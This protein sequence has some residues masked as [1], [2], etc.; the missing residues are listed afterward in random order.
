MK[1]LMTGT[2]L[3]AVLAIAAPAWAQTS[4]D[5]NRMELNQLSTGGPAPV[6]PAQPAPVAAPAPQP[7]AAAYP[8]PAYPAPAYPAPAYAAPAYPYPYAYLFD[9]RL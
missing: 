6:Y 4:E 3:V 1:Y 5:L 8:A 2:A 7:Y 9:P